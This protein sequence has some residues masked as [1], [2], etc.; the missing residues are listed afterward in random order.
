MPGKIQ[1]PLKDKI[2][3]TK[4]ECDWSG[5]TPKPHFVFSIIGSKGQDK[6]KEN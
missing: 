3:V 1:S 5:Q 6:E 4:V 2:F